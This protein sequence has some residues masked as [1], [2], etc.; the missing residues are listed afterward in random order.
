M[1]LLL[2]FLHNPKF[3]LRPVID[4]FQSHIQPLKKE[5]NWG[6]QIPYNLTGQLNQHPRAAMKFLAGDDSE[7]VLKFF[8]DIIEEE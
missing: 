2:G 5:L 3:K 6:P 1:E 7:N 4:C 8:D